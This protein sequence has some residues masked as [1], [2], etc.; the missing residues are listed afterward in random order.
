MHSQRVGGSL[1]R[2]ILAFWERF[3]REISFP[4]SFSGHPVPKARQVLRRGRSHLEY[5]GC[6]SKLIALTGDVYD[7]EL[8]DRKS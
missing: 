8:E 1:R 6:T 5:G 4:L 2:A 3:G 7:P